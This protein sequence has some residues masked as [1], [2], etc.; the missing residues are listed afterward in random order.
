MYH[1]P[2]ININKD[3][4]SVLSWKMDAYRDQKF[5]KDS[6]VA[7]NFWMHTMSLFMVNCKKMNET[8]HE[9]CDESFYDSEVLRDFLP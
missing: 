5:E 3:R 8:K 6:S 1:N 9:I 7:A 2:T 4:R